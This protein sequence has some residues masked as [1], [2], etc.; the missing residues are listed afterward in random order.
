MSSAKQTPFFDDYHVGGGT[1]LA[2]NATRYV[3][4]EVEVTRQPTGNPFYKPEWHTALTV[5]GTYRAKATLAAL[6]GP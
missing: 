5:K 6:C 1:R 2:V 3:A 4:G